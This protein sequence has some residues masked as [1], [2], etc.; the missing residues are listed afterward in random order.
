ME[1]PNTDSHILAVLELL[2]EDSPPSRFDSLLVRAR[3]EGLPDAELGRLSRAVQLARAL[4]ERPGRRRQWEDDLTALVDTAR[5]LMDA[6]DV[7]A[8]LRTVARRARRLLS[9]DIAFVVLTDL[10]GEIRGHAAEGSVTDLSTNVDLV[11]EGSVGAR[12]LRTKSPAW[13]ADC[14]LDHTFVTSK[15]LDEAT[16]AEGLR[17]LLAVPLRVGDSAVGVLYGAQRAVRHFTPDEIGAMIQ[18]ADLAALAVDNARLL[19]HARHQS[20]ELEQD[21]YRVRAGLVRLQELTDAYGRIMSLPL[22]GANLATIVSAAGAALDGRAR[23]FDPAGRLLASSEGEDEGAD[24]FAGAGVGSARSGS[25]PGRGGVAGARGTVA[26][27]ILDA[28]ARRTT[29]RTPGGVW[30]APVIAG[31][32]NLGYLVLDPETPLVG[33]DERLLQLAAQVC[34]VQLLIQ[35]SAGLTEGPQRDEL[36]DEL[37]SAPPRAPR[38]IAQRARQLGVDLDEPYV[39]VVMRPEGGD[40]GRAT[41]WSLSYVHRMTG[42]KTEHD[43]CMVLLLP[44]TDASAAARAVAGELSPLLGRP[45]SCG[46]AGPGRGVLEVRR[47]FQEAVRCLDAV[48]ALDAPGA[49]AAPQ[50]LGFLGVLLSDD[51]DVR[52]FVDSTIGPILRHDEEHFTEFAVTLEAYFAAKSSPTGAAG[53]LHVHPNTVSR[54][55][56][57]ITALLG[58]DWQN[59]GPLLEIQLALRLHRVRDVLRR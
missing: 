21:N 47:V 48:T 22:V 56:E 45:V 50:D 30:V 1:P 40:H 18:F 52:G 35:G 7:D 49:T 12:V 51:R 2:A 43:G 13:T 44:G 20:T 29:V 54:R 39:L 37:V 4:P 28:H 36:L 57:R 17:A 16:Q 34:A 6:P 58:P 24:G 41:V 25:G 23:L 19:Q 3:R 15:G 33:A 42:L 11:S 26:E 5:D 59:P 32:E 38:R 31:A 14:L 27:A 10:D 55:L 9:L 46:A 53:A 8:L